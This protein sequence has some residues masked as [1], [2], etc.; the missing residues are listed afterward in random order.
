MHLIRMQR[1]MRR[2]QDEVK[3][4]G[5]EKREVNH[6]RTERWEETQNVGRQINDEN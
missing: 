5:S 1:K 4:G 3:E 2:G 6:I